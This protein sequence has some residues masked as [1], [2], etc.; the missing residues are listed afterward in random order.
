MSMEKT[1]KCEK[2]CFWLKLMR[3]PCLEADI[4]NMRS[5]IIL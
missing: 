4:A 3:V 1:R 5:I 2:F